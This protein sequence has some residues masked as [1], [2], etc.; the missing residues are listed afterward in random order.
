MA[1]AMGLIGNRDQRL[2]VKTNI[3]TTPTLSPASRQLAVYLKFITGAMT[4][5]ARRQN[6]LKSHQSRRKS[7]VYMSNQRCSC[8][9][10]SSL[11]TILEVSMIYFLVINIYIFKLFCF[12]QFQ[13]NGEVT[14]NKCDCRRESS[15]F[16]KSRPPVINHLGHPDLYST[17]T[18]IHGGSVM[19]N[20]CSN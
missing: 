10:C 6:R 12:L 1:F 3:A 19:R 11:E 17:Q 14:F 16:R 4:S 5:K 8:E 9:S 7:L 2:N 18:F 13:E 20:Y 15:T